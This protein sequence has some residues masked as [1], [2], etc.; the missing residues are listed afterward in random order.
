[1]NVIK[2]K[3]LKQPVDK[4]KILKRILFIAEHPTKL[5]GV[6]VLSLAQQVTDELHNDIKTSDI[7]E[8]TAD[9]AANMILR[10]PDY[11][12]L[13]S[14]IIINN[15]H[16][17]TRTSFRDKVEE[18][19]LRK[20]IHGESHPLVSDTFYKFVVKNQK[21]IENHINYDNDYRFDFFGFKTLERSYLLQINGKII[22]RPQDM[23]MRVAIFTHMTE[24]YYNNDILQRILHT[25]NLYATQKICQASPTMFNAG[26][27]YPQVISCYLIGSHDSLEGINKTHND[28]SKISKWAGGIGIHMSMI[29]STGSL[30]RTTN[31]PSSGI[32]PILKMYNDAMC[33]YNQGGK[34]PGNAVIY[35]EPHHPDIF[36]FLDLKLIHGDDKLR[37]RDLFYALWISDLFMKRVENDEEWSL[38]CPD[39]CP[40]LNDVW[41]D[42]YE[43]LYKKYES[44]GLA[45]NVVPARKILFAIYQSM[46]ES[47]VPYIGFKDT[48]NRYNMQSN[49]GIIRSSNLCIEIVLYS[50]DREYAV[51]C[52]GNLVLPNYVY[53]TWTTDEL[54]I[55]ENKRR[56]LDHNFPVHPIFNYAELV[57]N[58]RY[59]VRNLDNLLDKNYYPVI[60]AARSACKTRAIGIGVQGLADV[61][62]KFKVPFESDAA[63]S[64]N[65][66]IFEAIHYGSLSESTQICQDIY[67]ELRKQIIQNGSVTYSPYSKC[68]LK[69]YPNLCEEPL[70]IKYTKQYTNVNDLPRTVGSYPMYLENGGSPLANGQYHWE[71]YGIKSTDLSGLFDWE[72]LREKIKIFGVR[73]SHLN[74]AM[75]TAST[76]QIM[77]SVESI[78][79]YKTNIYMR[80][81][82]AGEYAVIN[83]YLYKDFKD[84]GIDIEKAREYLLVGKGSVQHMPISAELKALY[85]TAYEIRKNKII[86]MASDRQPFIDQTQSM[87]LFF[88]DFTYD[89]HFYKIFLCAWKRKLKTGSY[90]IRTR[91]A[92]D[93][94]NITVD[95]DVEQYINQVK[96]PEQ[97]EEPICTG[98]Q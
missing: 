97:F 1:M 61:F 93:A 43:Q 19:Y 27:P 18:L 86:Q 56:V 62:M 20:D 94:Q 24:D 84:T 79:P 23:L 14:R 28:I 59:M 12:T 38:F 66:K 47:G 89:K 87:N 9:R 67:K 85:K 60:E 96:L 16:K 2:R 53:D 52:L 90:Y 29:R 50:D 49:V 83:K 76:S 39:E 63:A 75:P 81:T 13:A 46:K 71:M 92:A 5:Q 72:A 68:I 33:M 58:T 55:P 37:A 98:C 44:M 22:E 10:H 35:I 42:E 8:F 3:G 74:A 77:G 64:L 78:E 40:R 7:D 32:V 31:G 65:K 45:K 48:V 26:S 70:Y 54:K 69:Q 80:K 57:E 15:H 36:K 17:K 21:A 91:P 41:G 30:I 73:H 95:P 6:D 82:Q 11:A 34:R 51:C 88:Q 25:Y 4:N